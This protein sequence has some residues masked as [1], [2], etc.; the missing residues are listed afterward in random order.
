MA[1]IR[2]DLFTGYPRLIL[3]QDELLDGLP[4]LPALIGIFSVS[5]ALSLCVPGGAA[6]ERR[7]LPD[8]RGKVLP[9]WSAIRRYARTLVRSSFVG[10]AIGILPGAGT[11]VAAFISYNE[12]RRLSPHPE[13]FGKGEIEGVA[14]PEAANNA[15][16]GGSLVPTLTLGI[17]G[18]AV[19][20]VFIGGLTIHGLIP[21]PKLFPQYADVTY[22][23]I[24]SLFLA[25]IL[26]AIVGWLAAPWISRVIN[27]PNAILGPANHRVQ[28]HRLL[29]AA[30]LALR[31]LAGAWLRS[32]RLLHGALAVSGGA[33][34]DR[35]CPR[36]DSGDEL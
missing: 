20:A 21:G 33:A 26:F 32:D 14:A 19:T 4:L 29:C 24:L 22:T 12:A 36:T 17:P 8:I 27:V 18:N 3:G 23:L 31:C 10:S 9:A 1:I 30:Q 16:T 2:L 5:Q 34:G 35:A 6:S 15:V 28:R 11:S 7:P 25:N 13:R